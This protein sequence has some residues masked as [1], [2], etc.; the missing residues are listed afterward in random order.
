VRAVVN[1]QQRV[2][3]AAATVADVV[4]LLGHGPPGAGIAVAL[5]GEVV[6][7]A[8][9]ARTRMTEGDRV[10]ILEAAQGG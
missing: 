8:E 6:R 4:A 1:G 7:R 10:E 5:N 9:W 3:D 2:L